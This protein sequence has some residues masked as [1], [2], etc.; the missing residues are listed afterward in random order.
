[1]GKAD[2]H[3]HTTASD[4]SC[5]PVEIIQLA[6]SKFLNTISIT[7]HDTIDGYLAA[8][9]EA[10]KFAIRLIPGVEITAYHNRKE[11]HILAYDFNPKDITFRNF[12]T[13]QRKARLE[14]ME[15]IL[16]YLRSS[17]GIDLSLDEVKA[18][19]RSTNVGRPHLAQILVR[20]K[21]VA[22]IAEAFIRYLGSP[23]LENIEIEYADIEHVIDVVDQ[24][25]GAT[26]LAHPGA[27]YNMVETEE[28]LNFGL[29][30]IECIHPSHSYG[31]QKQFIELAEKNNLLI[32]GG[33]DFHGTGREY[34]P[35]FGIVTISEQ[36]LDR[37]QAMTGNRKKLQMEKE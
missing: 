26:V 25:T 2:L 10:R 32:T 16:H 36:K 28:Y 11:I 3:I 5:D 14:R 27:V 35:F 30:G 22:S 1:M 34:D 6:S 19:A 21:Y 24:A 20:K 23:M 13:S 17:Q 9:D 15:R 18:Q 33:S 29:D 31:E 8:V 7:D 4:G 37:L 12:L